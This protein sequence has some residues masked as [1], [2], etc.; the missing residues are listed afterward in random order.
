MV[1]TI[2]RHIQNTVKHRWKVFRKKS[3][4]VKIGFAGSEHVIAASVKNISNS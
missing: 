4:I 3:K 1:K 2:Q